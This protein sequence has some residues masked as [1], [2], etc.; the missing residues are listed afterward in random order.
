[1]KILFFILFNIFIYGQHFAPLRIHINNDS[2]SL[3]KEDFEENLLKERICKN[4]LLDYSIINLSN[5]DYAIIVDKDFFLVYDDVNYIEYLNP[6]DDLLKKQIFQP[7]ILIKS[8]TQITTTGFTDEGYYFRNLSNLKETVNKKILIVKANREYRIKKQISLPINNNN[9]K[10]GTFSQQIFLPI[11]S[12]GLTN[13]LLS[14]VLRQDSILIEKF[15][16]KKLKGKLKKKGIIF[17]DG[18]VHSNEIPII[19]K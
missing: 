6:K 7:A 5:K 1:M 12:H 18:F 19:V 2:I 17:Y 8:N 9:L 15:I 4:I 3:V 16:D 10:K 11:V 14:L 13:G